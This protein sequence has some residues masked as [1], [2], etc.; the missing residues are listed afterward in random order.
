[1]LIG[2]SNGNNMNV[3]TLNGNYSHVEL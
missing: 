1:V 3:E 2:P